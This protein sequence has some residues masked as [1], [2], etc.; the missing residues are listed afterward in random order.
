[1]T[2]SEHVAWAK[3]RALEYVDRGELSNAI[4][5]IVSDL[6]KHPET[7]GHA[8]VM[9]LFTLGLPLRADAVSK[10]IEGFR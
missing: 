3:Q 8:G 1:M 6:G 5:S 7:E 4:A 2:R 10:C 9:V